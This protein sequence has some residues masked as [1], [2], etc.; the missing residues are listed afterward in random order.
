MFNY[1]DQFPY[2]WEEV[3]LSIH[4]DDDRVRAE[5]V[6]VDAARA[7]ALV[8]SALRPD[9]LD[10]LE[11]RYGLSVGD[12]DPKVYCA[13]ADGWIELTVHFLVDDHGIRVVKDAVARDIIAGFE[14]AAIMV[15]SAS[16]EVTAITPLRIE[17][18][19]RS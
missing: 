11:R 17:R 8:I 3:S 16:L 18:V 1:T 6:M 13:L 5:A 2:V 14:K 19:S 10:R 12:I 15:A 4:F 9:D 7:H